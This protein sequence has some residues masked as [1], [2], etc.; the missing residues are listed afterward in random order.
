MLSLT[1]KEALCLLPLLVSLCCIKSWKSEKQS[2]QR[3]KKQ[4]FAHTD[5]RR[6]YQSDLCDTAVTDIEAPVIE[7]TRLAG[8]DSTVTDIN[9]KDPTD[10]SVKGFTTSLNKNILL[11]PDDEYNTFTLNAQAFVA[12]VKGFTTSTSRD[13]KAYPAINFKAFSEDF[14]Y[15][16]NP[17]KFG[18][19]CAQSSDSSCNHE[20]QQ[21]VPV[22]V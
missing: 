2:E 8:Y 11:C 5:R 7:S 14:D 10:S 16:N 21:P 22:S 20:L 19:S 6:Q 15:F 3:N 4:R 18:L 12:S 1:K 13:L 9:A 17:T